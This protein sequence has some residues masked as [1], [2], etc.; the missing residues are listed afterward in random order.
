MRNREPLEVGGVIYQQGCSECEDVYVG[1]TGRKACV[2]K[3]EHERDVREANVRSA[4]AEHVLEKN[5]RPDFNSFRII[6]KEKVWL[7]RKIKEAIYISQR[8]NF[9]RDK[10]VG[11]NSIWKRLLKD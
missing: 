7:R 1:E 4:I 6:D 3:R 10:G 2:R 8:S 5:H 9:N 11:L